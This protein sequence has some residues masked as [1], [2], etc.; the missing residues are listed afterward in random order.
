MLLLQNKLPAAAEIALG[1][2]ASVSVRAATMFEMDLAV[3][4][5]SKMLAG[6]IA[7]RESA[8]IAADFLG[9]EFDGADFNEPEWVEA[10][11]K[12]IILIELAVACVTGWTGFA[13]EAGNPIEKPSRAT[14]AL[15]LRSPDAARR[16]EAALRADINVELDEK[17]GSAASLTGEAAADATIAQS[18]DEP[19]SPAPTASLDQP[20]DIAPKSNGHP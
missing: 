7:A 10:A 16:I 4:K 12:R 18:A 17:N 5:A 14:L 13:D 11:A 2:G 1:A 3:A 9:V 8:T 20:V 19:T 15:L 6:L